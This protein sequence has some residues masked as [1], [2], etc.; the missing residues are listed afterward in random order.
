MSNCPVCQED[1]FSSRSAS[2]EM[3]CGHAIHWHCFRKLTSFD[4]RCPVCKKTAET[5]EV[6][7][8]IWDA[9]ATGIALQSVPPDLSRVVTIICNDCEVKET[10]RRWHFL[11]VQCRNC[12]SFNTTIDSTEL[13][14]LEAA[15]FLDANDEGYRNRDGDVGVG[16]GNSPLGNNMAAPFAVNVPV[17]TSQSRQTYEDHIRVTDTFFYG[18]DTESLTVRNSDENSQVLSNLD[19]FYEYVDDNDAGS[20]MESSQ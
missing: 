9:M 7:Q 8:P 11:G 19:L 16:V 14:G 18:N 3:P 4:T 10:G 13:V 1:L 20:E 5:H 17:S 12:N 2:H 6:M 15:A